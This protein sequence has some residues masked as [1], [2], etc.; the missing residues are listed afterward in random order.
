MWEWM[1]SHQHWLQC[2]SVTL[3]IFENVEQE[4]LS[5]LLSYREM[6]TIVFNNTAGCKHCT[7]QYRNS[8]RYRKG[9]RKHHTSM[10]LLF[11]WK[12]ECKEKDILIETSE[13]RGQ[14]YSIKY[15][16]G[17]FPVSNTLLYVSITSLTKSDSGRYR[18]YLD[19]W[20]RY[21]YREFEIRVEDGEFLPRVMKW[22]VHW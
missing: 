1:K 17:T 7:H 19:R 12:E 22:A 21:S 8:R 9:G 2:N 10:H 16:E 6:V 4:F 13:D 3:Q 11:L 18:C 15:I 20:T 14:S 5:I